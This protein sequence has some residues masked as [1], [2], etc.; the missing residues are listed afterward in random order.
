MK[1]IEVRSQEPGVRIEVEAIADF[2]FHSDFWLLT[3]D[4]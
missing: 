3:P 2:L 4:S 1:K